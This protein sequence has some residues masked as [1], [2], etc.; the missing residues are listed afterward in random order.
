MPS[1]GCPSGSRSSARKGAYSTG[2]ATITA[3]SVAGTFSSTIITRLSVP[4][5]KV[6]AMPTDTWNS[7][8]RSNR[9]NGK[10][11][12]AASA[13]GRKRGPNWAQRAISVRLSRFM[14]R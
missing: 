11:G 6:S 10:S 2:N 13:N 12:V 7:D 8:R 5:S 1:G 4:T 14:V 9:D 3:T